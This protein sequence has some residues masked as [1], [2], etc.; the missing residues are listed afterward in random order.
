LEGVVKFNDEWVVHADED[1]AFGHHMGLLLSFLDILLFEDFH[2]I[3]GVVVL[4][5]FLDEYDFG[6]GAFAND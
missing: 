3:N 1:V 5:L 2:G 6:V 4:T